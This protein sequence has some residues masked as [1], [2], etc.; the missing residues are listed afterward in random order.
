M[1]PSGSSRHWR[2]VRRS[3]TAST[4]P[5]RAAPTVLPSSAC[6]AADEPAATTVPAA[7]VADRQR[8]AEPAGQAPQP[9]R[10]D[11]CGDDRVVAACRRTCAVLMSAPPN[12]R[13]RSDGLIGAASTRTSTS[14]GPGVGTSTCATTA[15]ACRRH[16]RGCAVGA[17]WS[18][19]R[20]SGHLPAMPPPARCRTPGRHHRGSRQRITD[21]TVL[22][23]AVCSHPHRSLT[24]STMTKP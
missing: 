2:H 14:S 20:S 4:S 17:T 18:G 13:P 16:R 7:L 15:R 12:S 19:C 8:L 22:P 10:R 24:R 23:A 5:R 11:R 21:Q 6:A 9:G 1:T 3:G